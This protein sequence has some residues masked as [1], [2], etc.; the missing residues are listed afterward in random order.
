VMSRSVALFKDTLPSLDSHWRS[1]ILFGRNVASYK[2]A[3]AQAL[4]ELSERDD[5][6]VSLEE[7]ADPFSRHLYEHLRDIDKQTTSGSSKFL[8]ACRAF[9]AGELSR[10]DLLATTVKRGF[11][12]VIDAFHVVNQ[13]EIGVRFFADE[14]GGQR[15]GVRL[16]DDLLALR[17]TPQSRN[18]G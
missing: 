3:L 18:L 1:I 15:K 7:L 14:R 13:A 16:T 2:F 8:D 5:A 10:D 17:G 4:M 6:F 11:V 9:N 12:N